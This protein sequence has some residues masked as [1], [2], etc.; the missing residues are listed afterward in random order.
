MTYFEGARLS[1]RVVAEV[2]AHADREAPRE[3]CGL[4]VVR[5][6]RL[7]YV[8]CRNVAGDSAEFE[9][10]PDDWAAAE[11][12]GE[13]VAVCHSHVLIPPTPSLADR[14]MCER[15]GL[16]W[17]IVNHPRGTFR[18]IVPEGYRAP[19]V[20]RSYSHGVL[21][22]YTILQDYYRETLG[23][24]LPDVPH[25]DEW[26]LCGQD[27][28]RQHFEAAGFVQ[29]GDGTHRDIREHDG[30]LM[31]VASPVPN[32]GA[33]VLGDGQI[34]HHPAHRLSSRDVYGGYWREITTH[35]LRHRSLL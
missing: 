7:R 29:V 25:A 35:V 17:L 18:V 27:L 13:I 2:V 26:W 34:L 1:A 19:L 5:K 3:C 6:G 8:P 11:D 15:T 21:D 24:G 12:K 32:H 22:C 30:L 14:V 31:Q 10:P 28:Y 16:P 4:A 9:I 33:V 23:L 20:G